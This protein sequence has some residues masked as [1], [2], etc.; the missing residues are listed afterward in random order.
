MNG[1]AGEPPPMAPAAAGSDAGDAARRADA[2]TTP[3]DFVLTFQRTVLDSVRVA[4]VPGLAVLAAFVFVFWRR[5]GSSLWLTLTLGGCATLVLAVLGRRLDHRRR[6]R[7]AVLGI[8]T[9]AVSALFAYGPTLGVGLLFL[10]AITL[11]AWLLER[12]GATV[13]YL[14]LSAALLFGPLG[15][16]RGW[17]G[18][19]NEFPPES[20]LRIG[21]VA[22]FVLGAFM[23]VMRRIRLT[24]YEALSATFRAEDE[25]RRLQAQLLQAQK[26]EAV[27]QLAGGIAHDFNNIM[28]AMIMQLD[29]LLL[30]PGHSQHEIREAVRDLLGSAKRAADLTRKLLLFSRRQPMTSARHDANAMVLEISKLFERLLGEQVALVVAPRPS[31]SS[32]T[33][34]C[35]DGSRCAPCA[36]SAT[37]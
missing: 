3:D 8:G 4:T 10:S 6:T 26:M 31:W 33:T 9:M 20:W 29:T 14:G 13:T 34:S 30:E 24:H 19:P 11:A 27:G 35:C 37:R 2:N 16:S 25:R 23:L 5:S 28:A 32:R 7:I 21:T 17:L 22:V 1:R 15:V 36:A 18:Q 12:L